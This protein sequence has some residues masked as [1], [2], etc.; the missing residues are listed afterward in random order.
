MPDATRL[1][2]AIGLPLTHQ[3]E[4]TNFL[5]ELADPASPNY[6]KYLK[7]DEFAAKFG[8]AQADYDALKK[9]LTDNGVTVTKE[10]PNRTLLDVN[11]SAADIKRVFHVNMVT[12]QHPT[13]RR[14]FFAP[15]AEPSID[16]AI[17]L[18]HIAGLDNYFVPHP[19]ISK[20][21]PIS[22]AKATAPG[23]GSGPS[24][25]YFANDFRDAYVPGVILDG[26]GQSVGLLELD[27]YFPSDIQTY[28]T[29]G[30]LP[31]VSRW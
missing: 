26:S 13:E 18:L 28:E 12:Y 19:A 5:K 1:N 27:G 9:F 6:R 8:P 20:K 15:D 23:L 25:T 21:V 31:S 17:P 24:G 14:I 11:V 29:Q 16:L 10:Y 3:A 30:G 7:P 4:L 22:Q 2:L